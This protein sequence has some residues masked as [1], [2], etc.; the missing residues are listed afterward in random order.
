MHGWH[1]VLWAGPAVILAAIIIGWGA[2]TAQVYISQ[3]LALAVLAW[4]QTLPE[5][6]VEAVVAW[7]QRQDLMI[8]NLSGSLRLL[9]GLGWPLIYF[10][11]AILGKGRRDGKWPVIKLAAHN[12]LEVLVLFLGTLYFGV[13]WL[14]QTLTVL[15]GAL[16][17]CI[18][19]FYLWKLSSMPTGG[20]ED[21]EDLP[22]VG[23]KII[24]MSPTLRNISILS[25]FVAGGFILQYAAHPFLN[26]LEAVAVMY[27][28]STFVFIQ[29]CAPFVSEF[30]EKITAFQWARKGG[31]KVTM[32]ML[33]MVSSNIV[34][35]T[36]MAGMLPMIYSVSKGEITSIYFDQHQETEILLTILQSFLSVLFLMDLEFH[37]WDAFGLFLLW[38]I[39]FFVPDFREEIMY[40]Y[41]IWI[42]AEIFILARNKKLTYAISKYR[43]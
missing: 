3:G 12:G 43:G 36:M 13:V 19:F 40:V 17:F 38:A 24:K 29:W 5:F 20:H 8:A 11:Y 18:Y 31:R 26:G 9:V 4:L 37:F 21:V 33:N 28:I 16:L 10:T 7:N 23:K 25:I 39:Q 15:D 32:A 14:K 42:I 6:A 2:E 34:Q 35:W 30:P 22:W 41:G 1:D 27:G